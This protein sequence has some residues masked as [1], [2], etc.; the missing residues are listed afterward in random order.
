MVEEEQDRGEMNEREAKIFSN[1]SEISSSNWSGGSVKLMSQSPEKRPCLSHF[2]VAKNCIGAHESII[3][4]SYSG[5][6]FAQ[7]PAFIQRIH[8]ESELKDLAEFDEDTNDFSYFRRKDP[9][10]GDEA[11]KVEGSWENLDSDTCYLH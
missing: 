6:I 8:S 11:E 2:D 10:I 3:L 9:F 1:N 7:D 5:E 4:S